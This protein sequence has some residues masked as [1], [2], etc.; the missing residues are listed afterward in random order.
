[1]EESPFHLRHR[2]IYVVRRRISGVIIDSFYTRQEAK[3]C[4]RELG[5][6]SGA[7]VIEAQ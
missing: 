4:I 3:Q 6:E 1:M 7:F 2:I 5:E